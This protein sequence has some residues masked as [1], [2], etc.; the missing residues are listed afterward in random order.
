MIDRT[1]IICHNGPGSIFYRLF[2]NVLYFRLLSHAIIGVI[3]M[4]KRLAPV[5]L[6]LL[7]LLLSGCG[8]G[9][10]TPIILTG[11][12]F[13]LT[14]GRT[15]TYD[16]EVEAETAWD[17]FVTT[18]TFTRTVTGIVPVAVNG[19][20]TNAFEFTQIST[21]VSVPTGDDLGP[22]DRPI[23]RAVNKLFE[24]DQGLQ[25]VRAYYTE[26]AGP[27]DTTAITLVATAENGGPITPIEWPRPRLL[28]PPQDGY[29]E[30]ASHWF[31]P[32]PMMPPTRSLSQYTQRSK[33]LGYEVPP[34]LLAALEIYFFSAKINLDGLSGEFGGRG[35]TPFIRDVG[36][37]DALGLVSDWSATLQI[38][39]DWARITTRLIPRP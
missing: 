5:A 19:N 17:L 34:D 15:W 14:V 28:N 23:V 32:M 30:T 12:H 26:G 20:L 18:G 25:T 37:G 10:T 16:V 36:V 29:G 33:I 27:A 8:G 2:P 6:M 11:D 24:P 13:P 21:L 1:R 7:A 39:G 22:I 9:D 35:R 31:V 3:E 4:F 38:G